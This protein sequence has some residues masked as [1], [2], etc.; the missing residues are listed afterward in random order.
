[1]EYVFGNMWRRPALPAARLLGRQ[2]LPWRR[3]GHGDVR[4]HGVPWYSGY[5]PARS[6]VN[7][8]RKNKAPRA[9]LGTAPH[10]RRHRTAFVIGENQQP[11]CARHVLTC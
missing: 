2:Y 6:I 4:K 7:K 9:A 10:I 3:G 1:M 8:G 5:A 11:R